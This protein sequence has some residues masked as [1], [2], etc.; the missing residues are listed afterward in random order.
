M[1]HI[2][3][4]HPLRP[5]YRALA[6]LAGLYILVFGIV[7]AVRA[8]GTPAFSQDHLYWVLGLRT[9]LGFAALSI[10][11]GAL[12]LLA[13]AVGR[14]VDR[15]VNLWGSV[16]F[17]AV[18]TVMLGLMRTNANVLGFSMVNCIVSFLLGSLLLTAGLYGRSA[19]TT[20]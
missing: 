15:F 5:V 13:A 4:N 14:N 20:A 3:V 9:N 10:A 11:A 8:G 2:P 12:L 19:R 1:S 7:G 16:V 18:G 17:I 6:A